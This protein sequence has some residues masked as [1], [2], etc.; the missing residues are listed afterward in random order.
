MSANPSDGPRFPS[1]GDRL[2]EVRQPKARGRRT[3]LDDLLDWT[4]ESAF[5]YFARRG[6]YRASRVL[7][8][9]IVAQREAYTPSEPGLWLPMVFS[10]RH[11]VEL[12]LK[13]LLRKA[14]TLASL[15][16]RPQVAGLPRPGKKMLKHHELVPLW[17]AL[18]KVWRAVARPQDIGEVDDAVEELVRELHDWDPGSTFF[19]YPDHEGRVHPQEKIPTIDLDRWLDVTERLHQYFEAWDSYLDMLLDEQRDML[20]AMS[21]P[22]G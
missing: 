5:P 20:S 8:E 22:D 13:S 4:H 14:A 10:F 19:R 21:G 16:L 6:Y 3:P 7:A 12:S 2:F 11:Y 17:E 9:R 18:K 1:K 15:D